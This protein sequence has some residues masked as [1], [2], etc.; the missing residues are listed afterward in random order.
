MLANFIADCARV[1]QAIKDDTADVETQISALR[2]S[3]ALVSID[4]FSDDP[5][6]A[7]AVTDDSSFDECT[8]FNDGFLAITLLI[9]PAGYFYP[10]HDHLQMRVL[11]KVLTGGCLLVETDLADPIMFYFENAT[12]VQPARLTELSRAD[13]VQG[14]ISALG[15]DS[16]NLHAI[17]ATSP[18][19][20]LDVLFN[21]YDDARPCTFFK[22]IQAEAGEGTFALPWTGPDL[23]S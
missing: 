18:C 13:L 9:L 11:T 7:Q 17:S 12:G 4:T 19:V 23:P 6:F 21:Y 3:L 5:R 2:E 10:L 14:D 16:P 1:A 20:L 22:M 8:V 15:P